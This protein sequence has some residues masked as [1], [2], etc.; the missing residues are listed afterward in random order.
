M[1]LKKDFGLGLGTVIA[2]FS[3]FEGLNLL[4]LRPQLVPQFSIFGALRL[5]NSKSA[6]RTVLARKTAYFGESVHFKKYFTY[7]YKG[8]GEIQSFSVLTV[9]ICR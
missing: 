7:L 2:N 5:V 1:G 6:Y 8:G 4:W 9:G 3:F